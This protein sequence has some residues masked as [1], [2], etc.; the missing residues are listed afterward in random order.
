MYF[1]EL[2]KDFHTKASYF[3]WV[4]EHCVIIVIKII[5]FRF[6]SFFEWRPK[7]IVLILKSLL[8]R[9]QFSGR[10]VKH[11]RNFIKNPSICNYFFQTSLLI[12]I[13]FSL[14]TIIPKLHMV[15]LF[16]GGLIQ[17]FLQFIRHLF[18]IWVFDL[19]IHH[20]LITLCSFW[21]TFFSTAIAFIV[22]GNVVSIFSNLIFS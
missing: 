5:W 9:F 17:F 10:W 22:I 18:L 4:M 3:D 8:E 14:K 2:G 7:V 21:Y 19:A 6:N 11:N 1:H 20:I 15:L 16:D 12:R 13:Q